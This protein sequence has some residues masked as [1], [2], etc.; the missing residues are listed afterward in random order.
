MQRYP[1]FGSRLGNKLLDLFKN[2][3]SDSRRHILTTTGVSTKRS[4][5]SLYDSSYHLAITST[6]DLQVVMAAIKRV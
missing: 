5:Y 4:F 1:S 6:S 2:G 3:S